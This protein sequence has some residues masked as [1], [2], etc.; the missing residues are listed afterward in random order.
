MLINAATVLVQMEGERKG[1]KKGKN[2][3]HANT[4]PS[5]GKNVIKIG[6]KML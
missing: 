2:M 1:G 4:R 5:P 6:I 3:K